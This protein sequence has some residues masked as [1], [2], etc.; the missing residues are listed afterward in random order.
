[1]ADRP[2]SDRKSLGRF[3]VGVVLLAGLV[4]AS[5]AGAAPQILGLLA[6]G[7]P[8]DLTC[9]DGRCAAEFSSFC[10]QRERR[11]PG[12]LAA[13]KIASSG[14]VT[15]TI[16]SPE[17]EA[18]SMP[19]GGLVSIE[20]VRGYTVVRLSMPA[21]RIAAFGGVSASVTVGE[22]VSLVPV[23]DA[24]DPDPLTDNETTQATGPHR[25]LADDVF[26]AS[27]GM[28]E[29]ARTIRRMVNSAPPYGR[30]DERGRDR[31]WARTVRPDAS[32]S[33]AARRQAWQRYAACRRDLAEGRMFGLRDCLEGRLDEL[34]VDLNRRYWD[35]LTP[36]S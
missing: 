18:I 21:A 17:R 9:E 16:A 23:A 6:T 28:A 2:F 20:A 8:V 36:G 31:L 7:G 32:L 34:M 1:M 3:I 14:G 5:P 26:R 10:L 22:H 27:D 29:A 25:Q 11:G 19:A 15:L 12:Y 4:T 13:Y 33:E 30:L 24:G 35:R